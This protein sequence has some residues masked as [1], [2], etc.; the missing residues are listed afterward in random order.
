MERMLGEENS[1][2][3]KPGRNELGMPE[4]HKEGQ[5]AWKMVYEK[6]SGRK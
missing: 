3:E 5:C 1:Q 4:K 6:E 2:C